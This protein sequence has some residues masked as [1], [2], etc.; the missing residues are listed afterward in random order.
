[1]CQITI[2]HSSLVWK[3]EDSSDLAKKPFGGN[4]TKV[5]LLYEIKLPLIK[6]SA[7]KSHTT[8]QEILQ[9]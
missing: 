3:I 8:Q 4:G 9:H 7:V 6:K 5:N 2:L 1:M